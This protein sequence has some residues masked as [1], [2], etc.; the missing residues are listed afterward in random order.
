MIHRSDV[1]DYVQQALA[2][3]YDAERNTI[4][5]SIDRRI[6]IDMLAA[7]VWEWLAAGDRPIVD[8]TAVDLPGEG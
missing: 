4:V 6:Q 1:P 5:S 3:A 2:M 7:A 8:V